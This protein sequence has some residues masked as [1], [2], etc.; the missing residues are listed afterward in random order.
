[1]ASQMTQVEGA[2]ADETLARLR[3]GGVDLRDFRTLPCTV[4]RL[5]PPPALPA[6]D[7]PVRF[8][9]N[10][11]DCWLALE[12]VEGKNRQVRRMTAAV[13][14]PTLRLVR[15]AMGPIK[16]GDLPSGRWRPLTA[17][18]ESALNDAAN[19]S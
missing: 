13:G 12:L 8:R 15:V 6:R 4:Q 11:P 18:E 9:K 14:H 17:E 3:R 19:Y 2:P 7:P 10:V 1:M 16:L 5:E